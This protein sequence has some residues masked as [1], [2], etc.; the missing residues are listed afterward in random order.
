MSK[1]SIIV[2]DPPWTFSDKLN[3]SNVKRGAEANYPVLDIEIIKS[4]PIQKIVNNDALLALWV[5]ASLLREGLDV[6]NA[7][8]FRQTQI[9]NWIKTKKE[10]K[11]IDGPNNI[12][13]FG[14]GR[15]FRASSEIALIGIRGKI[16][17]HLK[18]KSQRNVALDPA[19]KHSQKPETLQD[20]LDVMFPNP[21]LRKIELFARRQR[22]D[23][24]CLG[25]EID[26]KDIRDALKELM[27]ASDI[28]A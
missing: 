11:L 4:L 3:N 15:I 22:K 9:F 27:D 28:A 25:N 10:I 7:F 14:M 13:S 1:F 16:Y 17:S 21:E 24:I 5:P 26:G 12:L 19:T 20:R 8:G 18:N 2:C 23:W 6:M